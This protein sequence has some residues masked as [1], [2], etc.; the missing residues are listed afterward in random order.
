MYSVCSLRLG[1]G[2][3][4]QVCDF[5]PRHIVPH[6]LW[7]LFSSIQL[8]EVSSSH[9]PSSSLHFRP[10]V[11]Q[12][13]ERSGAQDQRPEVWHQIPV[14]PFWPMWPLAALLPLWPQILTCQTG[15]L[16]GDHIVNVYMYSM[17]LSLRLPKTLA[18][19]FV[20]RKSWGN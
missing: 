2:H 13:A 18:L 17:M 16:T 6:S 10:L 1:Q 3:D 19:C 11:Q 4:T 8:R 14:H 5:R 7:D 12:E 20:Q 9:D 15:T